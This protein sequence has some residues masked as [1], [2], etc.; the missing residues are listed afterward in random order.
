MLL[1]NVKSLL[2]YVDL[3]YEQTLNKETCTISLEITLSH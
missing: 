1:D 2:Y 3:D